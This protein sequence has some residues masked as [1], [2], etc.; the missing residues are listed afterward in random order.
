MTRCQSNQSNAHRLLLVQRSKPAAPI[1]TDD[2]SKCVELPH[3]TTQSPKKGRSMK[4]KNAHNP[5]NG[6]PLAAPLTTPTTLSP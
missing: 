6:A 1:I 2:R 3:M 4:A 5:H